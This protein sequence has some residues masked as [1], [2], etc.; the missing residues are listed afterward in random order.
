MTMY[1]GIGQKQ[2]HALFVSDPGDYGRGEYWTDWPQA[3]EIYAKVGGQ[4]MV[5]EIRLKN[6]LHLPVE[7]VLSLARD[8]YH[9]TVVESGSAARLKGSTQLTAD[10]VA[11]GYDGIVVCGYETPGEWS[12]CLFDPQNS[13][14]P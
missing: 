3:A 2:N 13:R 7:E 6:A 12:A 5:R 9:T 11:K 1:R 4:V 14:D 8:V 10:M